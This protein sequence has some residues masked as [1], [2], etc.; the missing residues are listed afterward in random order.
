M[1]NTIQTNTK[2]PLLTQLIAGWHN[3]R[4]LIEGAT[5]YTQTAKLLEEFAELVAALMPEESPDAIYDEIV[6]MLN[7]MHERG[8]IKT[9]KTEDADAAFKDAI[10]DMYVVQTNLAERE[11][12]SMQAAIDSSWQEIKDRKGKMINGQ[13]VKEEDLAVLQE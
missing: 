1:I 12:Y 10:G 3:D 8:R 9:V 5:A 13:F 7:D 11:G 4:N 6:S 2:L